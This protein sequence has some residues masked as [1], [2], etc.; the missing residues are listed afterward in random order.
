MHT[1][2]IPRTGEP[3][4]CIGLGTWRTF[5]VGEAAS[6]RA[7][8]AEVLRV[9]REAGGRLV[10]SSPMYGR[11]EAVVGDLVRA[12]PEPRPFLATKIWTTGREAGIAQLEESER[13]M[14]APGRLDLVQVH[15]LLDLDV[16]LA[17]LR[18]WKESGRIRY[19]GATHHA[20]G[21]FDRLAALAEEGA[22]DFVQVPY[23]V[24]VRG[25]EARL[26]GAARDGGVAVLVMRPLESG[27]LATRLRDVPVPS[28][29]GELGCATWPQLLLKW[30]L[31]HPS[32]TCVIPAT[33]DPRHAAENVRAGEGP[34]PDEALR[35][36]ILAAARAA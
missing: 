31:G 23:S 2:P 16:Q 27:D 6:E 21:A 36:R 13:R 19:V 29:A 8:L 32:V 35:R 18:A 12:H 20:S 11:A 5:D 17:T 33:A 4:P 26:L 14:A 22:V 1:R 25:A 9:L 3:L 24:A 30:I 15:N 28:W 10:D 34:L 7:P